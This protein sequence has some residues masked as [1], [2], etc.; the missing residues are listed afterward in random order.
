[1]Q[2]MNPT[3]KHNARQLYQDILWYGVLAGSAQAFL[4]VFAAR[5]GATAFH[6]SLLTA[7]PAVVNLFVSL[8]AARWLEGRS[9]VRA[10]FTTSLWHRSGYLFLVLIPWL[11]VPATQTWV[12]AA[13]V[14][15]MAVPGAILAIAFNAM[16]ADLMPPEWRAHVVGRRNALLSLSMT[17]ASIFSGW[18]LDA[19]LFPLNY[20]LVFLIGLVGAVLSSYF[21]GRLR[22]ANGVPPR[23]G[24]PLQDLARPGLMRFGDTLRTGPG[25]RFMTRSAGRNLLRLDLLRGQ[26]GRFLLVMLAFY[27]FQFAP[28][29]LMPLYWV[30]DM[31][32]NDTTISIGNAL[33]Y[34]AMFV[35]SLRLDRMMVRLGHFRILWISAVL[36]CLYP[37]VMAVAR[38][39]TLFWVASILGGGVWGVASGALVTRLMERVSEAD[40]AAQM[41]MHNL[42]LNLGILAG[43]LLGPI[44]G[45]WLGLRDAMFAT[46]ALRLLGGLLLIV[47]G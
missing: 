8:P 29:P 17:V 28:V 41:A 37:L 36:Y 32:L 25:L 27:T 23:I 21:L 3:V 30:Q 44:L 16:F 10:T 38:D 40:R 42:V 1:M 26:Y 4:A 46:A 20:Q 31:R 14:V 18:L 43:S 35:V 13:L 6:L 19:V 11:F 39:A 12:V 22:P 47:W 34:G 15:L 7:G 9:L 24:K 45:D 33:F 2:R 5:L